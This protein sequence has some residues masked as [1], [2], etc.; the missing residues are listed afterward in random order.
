MTTP[1]ESKWKSRF[2]RPYSKRNRVIISREEVEKAQDDYFSDGGKIHYMTADNRL[3]E[4]ILI[5]FEDSY[6]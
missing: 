6:L 4:D 5:H 1:K 2:P 3:V